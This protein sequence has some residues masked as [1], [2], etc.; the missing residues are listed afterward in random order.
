M[1]ESIV[2]AILEQLTAITIGKASEAWCLVSGVEEEVK[3]LERN[4]KSLQLE[5]EDAE[6]REYQDKRLKHWLDKFRDVSYDMEDVLDDWKIAIGQLQRV[7]GSVRKWKVC[8]FFSCFSSGPQTVR[9]YGIA[10]KI[11]GINE[12]LDQIVNDQVRFELI[13]KK[14]NKEHKRRLETT[15]FVDVSELIGR[16]AVK[17]DIIR[18]LLCNER[19]RNIP[20]ISI[21]GM[22]GTGKTALAQ[23]V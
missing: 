3:R 16:D 20:T 10:T 23:L 6:E 9:R 15:S 5:L 19:S 7:G 21:V 1:A 4:F 14:E 22:G 13:R 11:K 17:E 8:P 18:I 12:Q 2:S